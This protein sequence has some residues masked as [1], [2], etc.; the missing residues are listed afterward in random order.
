MNRP[1]N[2]ALIMLAAAL[3]MIAGCA[4]PEATVKTEQP[5][6]P[7]AAP[8]KPAGPAITITVASINLGSVARRI[9]QGDIDDLCQTV[10]R[11]KADILAVQGI[12]RYPGVATRIDVYQEIAA[13]TGMRSVFGETMTLSGRQGGNALYSTYPI[14]SHENTP[15]AGIASTNFESAL[16]GLVDA[17]AREIAVVSTLLPE[18]ASAGELIA[19]Q[20]ALA[21]LRDSYR[22]TPIIITGNLPKPSTD[23]GDRAPFTLE[24]AAEFTSVRSWY[25][26]E[27]LRAVSSRS[28]R[29]ALGQILITQYGVYRKAGP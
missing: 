27:G 17:G 16:L 11:E 13:V 21:A 8:K 7:P 5:P 1:L 9:E 6:P 4:K 26:S 10:L 15:Y 25:T 18:K 12:T 20:S 24:Q 2:A 3:L 14:S 19:C 28:V 29:S 23:A 22:G